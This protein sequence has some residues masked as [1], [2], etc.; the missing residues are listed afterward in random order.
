[1][2]IVGERGETLA[3]GEVGELL[4]YGP[5]VVK[6]YWQK[7]EATRDTFVDG[8]VRTGDLAKID[9]EGFLYIV[10]RKKD[11]LIRGGE[12]IYCVEVENALFEHP[13]VMDAGVIGLPHLQLGEEPAAV[14]TIKEGFSVSEEALRAFVRGRLASFKVPVRIVQLPTTLPRNAN[15]KILKKEL[16]PLFE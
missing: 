13:A 12:N 1:V 16:R 11:M 10:D 8:W 14:V 15:G 4:A 3:F 6:G 2:K 9:A 5:I 7:P